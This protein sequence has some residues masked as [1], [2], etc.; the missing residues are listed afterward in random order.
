MQDEIRRGEVAT[1]GGKK[2]QQTEMGQ[3]EMGK[4]RTE[5]VSESRPGQGEGGKG[6][7]EARQDTGI[8]RG[9]GWRY[10]EKKKTLFSL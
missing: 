10:E 8:M 6:T 4:D 7:K 5:G 1:P 9:C 3:T 2:R